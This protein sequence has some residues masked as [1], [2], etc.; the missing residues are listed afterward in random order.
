M[1]INYQILSPVILINE[2]A[3]SKN[4]KIIG[5]AGIFTGDVKPWCS[6]IFKFGVAKDSGKRKRNSKQKSHLAYS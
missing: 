6:F 5:I 1:C 2:L 3:L 4:I